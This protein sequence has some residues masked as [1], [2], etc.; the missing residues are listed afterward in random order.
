M[1]TFA[2]FERDLRRMLRNPLTLF[3]SVLM[4]LLYLVILG[5]S[6]Q[7]PIKGL[8]LGVVVHDRG[9]LARELLGALQALEHGPGTVRLVPLADEQHALGLLRDGELS[10]VVVVPPRFSS[11]LARGQSAN[12]GLYLDNVDAVAAG[13]LQSAI[14]AALP[15]MRRPLARFELHRGEARVL[16]Q[17]IYPR[18]DYDTSLVPAV[19]V[20]AIFM[21]SMIAGGFNLVMDRFLGVHESYLSTPLSR[22][23]IALGV[24]ASGTLVT[25]VSSSVVLWSGLLFTGGRVHGGV[26]GYLALLAVQL[27]TTFGLLAMMMAV[28]G[29]ASHPR[30]SGVLS[31][32]LNVILFFPSGALYPLAS[33][34]PWLRAIAMVDPETH[35]VAALK[36]ILFRSGDLAAAGTHVV[37]LALFAVAMTALAVTTL[38]RTL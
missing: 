7:G 11:D 18:V 37:F 8:P 4:P 30:I 15:A 13:A 14:S 25:L 23:N 17:E 3:S 29:R 16:P 24:L 22:W 19:V 36:A 9:P 27:L 31:G 35:A 28:L 12:I 26:A 6:L 1:K 34:P 32:F 21:G 38:K 2:V 10:G 33:F 5:N 20:M